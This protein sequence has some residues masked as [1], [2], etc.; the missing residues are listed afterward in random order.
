[1]RT[2]VVA[3]HFSPETGTPYWLNWAKEAGSIPGR[4]WVASLTWRGSVVRQERAEGA[5][6]ELWVLRAYK[7]RPFH[8]FET[9]G[10]TGL[11]TQRLLGTITASTTR[12][13]RPRSTMRPSSGRFAD[14]GPT[15]PR[16]LRLAMEHLANER[17][18]SAY[19][20]DLIPL[21]PQDPAR[22]IT[23][24]HVATRTM[25]STRPS[26]SSSTA[27]CAAC[28]PRPGCSAP[29]RAA[30]LADAGIRGVLCGE[31]MSPQTVRF[32]VEEVLQNRV[33]FTAVYGN[34]LM[35]WRAASRCQA[36]WVRVSP[37]PCRGR[38]CGWW[39]S[40][41]RRPTRRARPR[42]A[43]HTHRR[44]LHAAAAGAGRGGSHVLP[45]PRTPGT[46]WGRAPSRRPEERH[47]RGGH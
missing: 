9:G 2:F 11:P 41:A 10:T 36:P 47:H 14:P 26:P 12:S 1:M 22:A 34:T 43:D 18:S 45:R 21:G 8:I 40:R 6:H 42:R 44:V 37:C 27:T 13:L 17:S 25:S 3:H 7:H 4:K 24:R 5:P 31:P 38:C 30:S 20:V 29:G 23:P 39:T 35:A 28:S 15:G 46:G 33:T 16:R 19:H 32:L